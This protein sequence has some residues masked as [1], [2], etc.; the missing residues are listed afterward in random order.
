MTKIQQD[1]VG[2]AAALSRAVE[3]AYGWEEGRGLSISNVALVSIQYDANT[4]EL[5]KTVQRADALQGTRGAANLQASVAEGIQ[6]AGA[7]SGAEGILGIGFAGG[8]I[9][10]NGLLN[11]AQSQN[12]A[13]EENFLQNLAELKKAFDDGLITKKEFDSA[14]AKALGLN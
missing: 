4:S 12:Q 8:A 11:P 5:L 13:K 3:E 2:F 9:G 1:S 6:S 7:T 10:L 14:R